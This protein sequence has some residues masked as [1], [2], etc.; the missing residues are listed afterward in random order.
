MFD[1]PAAIIDLFEMS[2][3]VH[4]QLKVQQKRGTV[5]EFGGFGGLNRRVKPEKGE[6]NEES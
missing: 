6:G 3:M 2:L 4:S 5:Y 1:S